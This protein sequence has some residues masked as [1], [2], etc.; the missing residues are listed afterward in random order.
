MIN[1]KINELI[2]LLRIK[3][4][5]KKICFHMAFKIWRRVKAEYFARYVGVW[6]K[7]T[8]WWLQP[9]IDFKQCH[10]R[11]ILSPFK[12]D[13]NSAAANRATFCVVF[14]AEGSSSI[15]RFDFVS[16][17][18]LFSFPCSSLNTC[19][20]DPIAGERGVKWEYRRPTACHFKYFYELQT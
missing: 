15:L 3:S 16:L 4:L 11:N 6:D 19:K 1:N 5:F 7:G 9:R 14:C 20:T 10:P 18:W 17:F 2:T 8:N 12:P 13:Q